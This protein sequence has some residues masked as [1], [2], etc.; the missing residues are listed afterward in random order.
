MLGNMHISIYK[1]KTFSG[2]KFAFLRGIY[3]KIKKI[4]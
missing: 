4:N 2:I 1:S 3:Y